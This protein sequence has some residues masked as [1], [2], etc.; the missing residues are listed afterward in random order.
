MA[1]SKCASSNKVASQPRDCTSLTVEDLESFK[2]RY[3]CVRDNGQ[4]LAAGLQEN[5]VSDRI[6][7]LTIA[8]AD[9]TADQ[10]SCLY[11]DLMDTFVQEVTNIIVN[12]DC[13]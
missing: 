13:T 7:Q 5:Q 4:W 12:T 6:S 2:T 1:C 8:I 10:N 11:Y 9:K 3:E